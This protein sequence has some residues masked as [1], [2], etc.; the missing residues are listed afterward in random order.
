[1]ELV[2]GCMGF[3]RCF[4]AEFIV[5]CCCVLWFGDVV[6]NEGAVVGGVRCDTEKSQLTSGE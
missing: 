4:V 6:V 3:V 2:S 1:M 5:R